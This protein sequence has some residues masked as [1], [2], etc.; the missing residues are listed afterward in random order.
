MVAQTTVK[1]H[2][3]QKKKINQQK[4]IKER[5]EKRKITKKKKIITTMGNITPGM[6]HY[7]R[8]G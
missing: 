1:R 3:K 7:P 4:I 5:T 8:N 6:E 2:G